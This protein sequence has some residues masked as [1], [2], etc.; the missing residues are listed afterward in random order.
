M[1]KRTTRRPCLTSL[2]RVLPRSEVRRPQVRRSR[3]P[4]ILRARD[5]VVTRAKLVSLEPMQLCSLVR[6]TPRG[7][8]R[9]DG[10]ARPAQS[11]TRALAHSLALLASRVHQGLPPCPVPRLPR[12]PQTPWP[13]VLGVGDSASSVEQPQTKD[14]HSMRTRRG[15]RKATRRTRSATRLRFPSLVLLAL[16]ALTLTPRRLRSACIHAPFPPCLLPASPHAAAKLD[17][18]I[19]SRP[20]P[21]LGASTASRLLDLRHARH[22]TARYPSDPS[23]ARRGKSPPLA[24]QRCWLARSLIRHRGSCVSYVS[25]AFVPSKRR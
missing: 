5:V 14:R 22:A 7:V 9:V 15:T 13:R 19:A 23:V 2:V 12:T 17:R 11:R 6:A 20:S 3:D 1:V 21:G 16:V 10:V 25:D 18:S 8:P 24:L 4:L